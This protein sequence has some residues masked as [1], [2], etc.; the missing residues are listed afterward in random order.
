MKE[1][2]L[3]Q[4]TNT[5]TENKNQEEEQEEEEEFKW[6]NDPDT[7]VCSLVSTLSRNFFNMGFICNESKNGI[8]WSC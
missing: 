5:T 1:K 7:V 2:D 6:P 8:E 4:Q 3:N